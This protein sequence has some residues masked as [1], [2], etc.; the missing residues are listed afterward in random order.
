M[1]GQSM[2]QARAH[3]QLLQTA[4]VRIDRAAVSVLFKLHLRGDTPLRVT[5]IAALLG[6]DP[7][8]VTRKVQQLERL[9]YVT[10]DADP[11]DGRATRI[12]IAESGRDVLERVLDA[13]R[14]L[15]ADS[16]EEWSDADVRTFGAML[17]RF[18]TALS[19]KLESIS[20]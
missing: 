18:A 20:D 1:L 17:E 5:E 12:H 9:G 11:E 2:T 16:F 15:L 10:R 4:G 19:T 14:R 7:P 8:S 3:E 13:H 6:V